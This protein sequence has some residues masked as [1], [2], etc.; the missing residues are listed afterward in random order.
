MGKSSEEKEI[1]RLDSGLGEWD[2]ES[3]RK[4]SF[5]SQGRL[6]PDFA[7]EK[8]SKDSNESGR[9]EMNKMNTNKDSAKR[10]RSGIDMVNGS[11]VMANASQYDRHTPLVRAHLPKIP[12]SNRASGIWARKI[13]PAGIQYLK[14][15]DEMEEIVRNGKLTMVPRKISDHIPTV[16]I[17]SVDRFLLWEW[18]ENLGL[19]DEDLQIYKTP[20]CDIYELHRHRWEFFGKMD[21]RKMMLLSLDGNAWMNGQQK[22]E[23]M[24]G[25]VSEKDQ[26][27]MQKMLDM[28]YSADEVV[29]HFME[30]AEKKG[31][32]MGL[33][34]KLMSLMNEDLTD[35][36]AIEL[37]RE[38]LGEKSQK[39]MEELIKQGYSAKEVMQKMMAEGQTKEEE[40][41]ETAE[42]MKHLLATKKKNIKT[43]QKDVQ[44]M[45]EERLDDESKEKMKEMLAQG[46]P[47]QE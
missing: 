16:P 28:G 42:T 29:N 36:Q 24:M 8:S 43:S 15:E 38:E 26:K 30:D 17:H 34:R 47:L 13:S 45:L 5:S 46:I 3:S 20:V 21:F 35:D 11:P 31:G 6:S 2:S 9:G 7:M 22:L 18:N 32:N 1:T 4:T 10:R 23:M 25:L 33:T 19:E 12:K 39:K 44:A 14:M 27:K 41:K 40:L 37:M